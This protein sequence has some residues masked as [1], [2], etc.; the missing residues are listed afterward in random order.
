MGEPII[1]Y[2]FTCNPERHHQKDRRQKAPSA[3]IVQ[4][5]GNNRSHILVRRKVLDRRV[6]ENYPLNK[7]SFKR[8]IGRRP[9]DGKSWFI[10]TFES[11]IK[12]RW[13]VQD[14]GDKMICP[15]CINNS[16]SDKIVIII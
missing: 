7:T 8:S 3:K 11:A 14:D 2:C 6:V 16:G 13:D 1:L 10:G 5:P 15:R 12:E 4:F 9:F